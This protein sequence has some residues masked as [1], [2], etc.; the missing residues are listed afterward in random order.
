MTSASTRPALRLAASGVDLPRAIDAFLSPDDD[1]RGL[2]PLFWSN[3]N[4]YGQVPARHDHAGRS[5][6]SAN[7]LWS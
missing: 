2:T 3:I 5:R 4:P 6:V 1:R 7:D